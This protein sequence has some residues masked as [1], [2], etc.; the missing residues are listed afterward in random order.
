MF[1]KLM[2]NNARRNFQ[3]KNPIKKTA[4]LEKLIYNFQE[5]KDELFYACWQKYKNLLNA[6]PIMVMILAIF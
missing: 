4:T 2:G 1:Y 3:K 6:I 5:G